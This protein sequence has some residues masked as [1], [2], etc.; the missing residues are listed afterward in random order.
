VDTCFLDVINSE[1]VVARKTVLASQKEVCH[2]AQISERGLP[3][4]P[5]LTP[6]PNTE[7]LRRDK[8]IMRPALSTARS[9]DRVDLC[10][11]ERRRA[12]SYIDSDI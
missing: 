1:S 6:A 9:R 2:P 7:R 11:W 12:L 8:S 3:F 4:L 10:W 5:L